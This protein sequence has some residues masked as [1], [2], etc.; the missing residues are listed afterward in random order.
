MN[1][2][3]CSLCGFFF[4]SFVSK[5]IG[6]TTFLCLKLEKRMRKAEYG[7]KNAAAVIRQEHIQTGILIITQR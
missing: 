5:E 6:K 4:S 1:I 2:I 7:W 3:K